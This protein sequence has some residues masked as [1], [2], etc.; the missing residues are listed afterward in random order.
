MTEVAA[1]AVAA[2]GN[3]ASGQESLA[4]DGGGRGQDVAA[5]AAAGHDRV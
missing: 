5:A 4:R 3:L 2:D 1:A